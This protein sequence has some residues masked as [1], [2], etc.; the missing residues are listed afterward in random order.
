FHPPLG[1]EIGI[2][3]LESSLD[4][5]CALDRI[6]DAGEFG[7]DTIA[8]GVD[9]TAAVMRDEPIDDL[10][11]RGQDTER[12]LLILTHEAAIAVDVGAQNRSELTLQYSPLDDGDTRAASLLFQIAVSGGGG[13]TRA[14]MD[15]SGF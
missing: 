15:G 12:R 3:R 9:E 10:A 13:S 6:H 7:Q 8:G 11:V 5:D 4:L 2:F 14:E 1:W